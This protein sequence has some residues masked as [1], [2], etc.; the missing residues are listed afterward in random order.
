MY[1]R[2]KELWQGINPIH[3]Q[4]LAKVNACT[5]LNVY[6]Q[7]GISEVNSAHENSSEICC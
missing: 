3:L 2:L 5:A 4:A 7:L 6:F 1:E